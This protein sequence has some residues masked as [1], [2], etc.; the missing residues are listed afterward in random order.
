MLNG[1]A[2]RG[3]V[4]RVGSR[5]H[6]LCRRG[7]LSPF[8][9]AVK[10]WIHGLKHGKEFG[11]TLRRAIVETLGRFDRDLYYYMRFLGMYLTRED[12]R[13]LSRFLGPLGWGFAYP[14]I[15]VIFTG[16][17]S[18]KHPFEFQVEVELMVGAFDLVEDRWLR[19]E[20]GWLTSEAKELVLDVAD[21]TADDT[22]RAM[23]EAIVDNWE[24]LG[25][26]FIMSALWHSF[27]YRIDVRWCAV[28]VQKQNLYGS[29]NV[30]EYNYWI[31]RKMYPDMGSEAVEYPELAKKYFI[32]YYQARRGIPRGAKR[33]GIVES[34]A[35]KVLLEQAYRKLSEFYARKRQQ[36][37]LAL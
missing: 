18:E 37:I 19:L 23:L 6:E 33:S 36:E 27:E 26:D 34:G 8:V 16:E 3:Y 13:Y 25:F 29:F 22:G 24:V 4:T 32:D 5:I 1:V 2:S 28:S 12:S 11:Y 10:V 17:Y 21:L 15:K 7:F 20:A 35:F 30:Y 9:R 14:A 31:V